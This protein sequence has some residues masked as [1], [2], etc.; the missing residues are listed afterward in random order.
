MSDP[1]SWFCVEESQLDVCPDGDFTGS[2]ID[3]E[4]EEWVCADNYV[5]A[6]I[7]EYCVS[8]EDVDNCPDGDTTTYID[9]G[10]CEFGVCIDPDRDFI[11]EY[12][13][14]FESFDE[15]VF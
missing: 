15:F 3:G 2:W 8:E 12:E 1:L 4:C 13:E 6:P 14:C 9:D 11:A 5:L 10:M 7:F